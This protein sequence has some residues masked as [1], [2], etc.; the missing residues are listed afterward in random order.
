M[1][2]E[3][4]LDRLEKQNRNQRRGL[5]GLLL[6][7]LVVALPLS[8]ASKEES[9]IGRYQMR[10]SSNGRAVWRLDTATGELCYWN[11]TL[12][13]WVRAANGSPVSREEAA[14]I[15]KAESLSEKL[16]WGTLFDD[17]GNI[18]HQVPK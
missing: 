14:K 17:K 9:Q 6:L 3:E 2:T 1:N 12:R 15:R 7:V 13:H 11:L 16:S 4:R 8:C 5:V 10:T 18:I